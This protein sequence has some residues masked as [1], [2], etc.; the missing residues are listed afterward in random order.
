MNIQKFR[1]AAVVSGLALATG[2]VLTQDRP[3][4]PRAGTG[5]RFRRG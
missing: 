1:M 3:P 4:R 2:S 5:R